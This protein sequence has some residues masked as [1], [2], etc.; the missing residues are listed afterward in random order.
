MMKTCFDDNE[1]L[2]GAALVKPHFPPNISLSDLVS[3]KKN[4]EVPSRSP[5]AFMIYRK[6]FVSELH[7][8]GYYLSMTTTS[9]LASASWKKE[10][11]EVKNEYKRLACE[12]KSRHL[13]LYSNKI[14]Q[15]KRSNKIHRATWLHVTSQSPNFNTETSFSP[16]DSPVPNTS[17]IEM[18]IPDQVTP[19]D[20]PPT[21]D[22]VACFYA[23]EATQI[24]PQ[25][26]FEYNLENTL[27]PN[28][29]TPD[30]NPDPNFYQYSTNLH[31]IHEYLMSDIQS[32]SY[33][34]PNQ[35]VNYNHHFNY[36][37]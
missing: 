22:S 31:L 16:M 36:F 27:A 35:S 29:V 6:A 19:F 25:E 33:E 32:Q 8:N 18:G 23:P 20:H 2:P 11:E 4:G 26:F 14:P 3:N 24:F 34:L 5:N 7:N 17:P 28:F 13:R 30:L 9:S 1:I 12:A 37:P 21:S 15:K 10:S